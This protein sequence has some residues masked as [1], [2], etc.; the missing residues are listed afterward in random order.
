MAKTRRNYTGNAV[1]TTTAASIAA[2]GTTSFTIADATGWPYGA[3]PFYIVVEPGSSSEEKILVTRAGSTDTTLSVY[4]TPSIGAN[5]GLDGTV[6]VSHSSGSVVYPVF[7]AL[8]AD[9]ANELTSKYTTKGDIVTHGSSTFVTVGVGTNNFALVADSAQAAGIKWGQ[10]QTAGIADDAVT[11]AKIVTGAVGTTEIADDSVTSAKIPAN[12]VT[13]VKIADNA[14]TTVKIPDDAITSA[15]IAASAVATA[16]IADAAVTTAKLAN[17]SV[18]ADKIAANAVGTSEI[19]DASVTSAKIASG[20][21]PAAV[22]TGSVTAYAGA[23]APSGWVLCDG[24]AYGRTDGT[25]SAL[26]AVVGT[27]YGAGNGTTTFNVPDLRTRVP[28]GYSATDTDTD[29]SAGINNALNTLGK[30]GG[31][32]THTLLTAE[33]PLHTHVFNH[34]HTVAERAVN[35]STGTGATALAA[36]GGYAALSGTTAQDPT[37]TSSRGNDNAHNNLQPYLVMNYIIK[38]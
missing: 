2:S 10:I 24:A 6:A 31:S 20:V 11:A 22:P 30:A 29:P 16:K 23:T 33:M 28:V 9:E 14:V 7:T 5:R 35:V 13:T 25:Y 38:L 19:A 12:A 21:L 4:S 26:Y 27:T 32:K 8:D 17:D 34:E 3:A 36:S 18:T 37:S 15:K 1:A